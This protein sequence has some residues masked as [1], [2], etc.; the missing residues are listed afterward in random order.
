MA[1]VIRRLQST[2][3]ARLSVVT[4]GQHREML[5][6]VLDFFGIVPDIKLD[7][8]QEGQSLADLTARL[9]VDLRVVFQGLRP[10]LVFVHG[11]TTTTFA[12]AL[13]AFYCKIP[14]A[15]VEAGLRTNDIYSP[16]PE[17]VNRR[18]TGALSSFNFAPTEHARSALLAEGHSRDNIW[19]TGNTVIDAL[20]DAVQLINDQPDLQRRISNALPMGRHGKRRI[21]VT[22]HRRENFDSGLSSLCE[23]LNKLV[24]RGDVEILF[25]IHLNPTVQNI[26]RGS[27]SGN[28]DIH[29]L[30]PLNYPTF[31]AA[32][33]SSY[34]ILTDSG[35]VQE[36]APSLGKPVL[37]LRD[38][39]ER[40]EAVDAGTVRVIGTES[41][42]IIE[43]VNFLLDHETRY[44][45]MSMAHNP[46]GDGQ[47]SDRIV[48]ALR[49]RWKDI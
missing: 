28:P 33:R 21:L 35:G 24:Q 46:Y 1:P 9:L 10:S 31:V 5:D 40:P 48:M 38:T 26:V 27:L 8:M 7:V 17:E 37:V 2:C 16:W 20:M 13:S 34:L 30:P 42:R 11:D 47:A 32:M 45:Q 14:V 19:V 6:Q 43:E 12:A 44:V 36:E 15:H 23:A 49:E 41:A 3:E 4:S 25:P 18:L 39:T 29:L 22:G